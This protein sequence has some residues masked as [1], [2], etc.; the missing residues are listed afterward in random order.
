MPARGI[1]AE[2]GAII[3]SE[4]NASATA[5]SAT[6]RNFGVIVHLS[7]LVSGDHHLAPDDRDASLLSCDGGHNLAVCYRRKISFR[8]V[9]GV[10]CRVAFCTAVDVADTKRNHRYRGYQAV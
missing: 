10:L 5:A 3:T 1:V 2:A 9:A 7:C 4:P 6:V 8:P